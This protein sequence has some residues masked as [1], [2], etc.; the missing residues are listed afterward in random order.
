[1]SAPVPVTLHLT[2]AYHATS[3]GIRTFYRALLSGADDRGRVMHLVVP[4]D[5]DATETVGARGWIHHLAARPAP[6]FDR[7]YR[8]LRPRHYDGPHSP[9]RTTIARVRPNLVEISDK[10]SLA[11][12]A[13]RLRQ[14]NSERP[15]LVGFSAE[16]MDDNVAAWLSGSSL[17]R[18]ATHRYMRHVY[19]PPFD[20]HVANSAYTAGEL[21]DA[22][23]RALHVCGMGVDVPTFASATFDPALRASLVEAAGGGTSS[24]LLLYAGRVSPEKHLDLV[25][26]A[27][28][29]LGVRA[30]TDLDPRLVVLGDGPALDALR[31]RAAR[32]CPGRVAFLP[33]LVDRRSLAQHYAAADVFVHPNPREPFGI[34]PLEAMAAGVPVVVPRAG[35]VLAYA[36]DE[37]A[38]LAAPDARGLA[39]AVVLALRGGRDD[40][41]IHHARQTAAAHAWPL[42][43]DR[44]F[45][46]IDAVHAARQEARAPVRAH[47]AAPA[48]A[49]S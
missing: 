1:M 8:L 11:P 6:G 40:A 28:A 45:R 48:R 49:S 3:G 41:R 29:M 27:V 7:R 38:W 46:V 30:T 47:A 34:G 4:S 12:L 15:T 32:R 36:T 19:V 20:A 35:G 44:Y 9:V 10:Y 42:V 26:D 24:R 17:A 5:R 2:N 21:S 33:H 14:T 31:V 23:A 16:R 13:W 22:G 18:R 37:N 43:V 25:I 39:D